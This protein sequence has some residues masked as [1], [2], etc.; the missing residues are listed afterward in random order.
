[1]TDARQ[2]RQIGPYQ[3][4][5]VHGAGSMG[6]V[7]RAYDPAIGRDVAVKLVRIDASSTRDHAAA[8]DRLRIEARA[9]GRCLHPGIVSVFDFVEQEGATPAIVMEF[10]EGR[11]LHSHLRDKTA[12]AAL[13]PV[14]L[15]RQILAPLGY[16]HSQASS[17][18]TSSRPTS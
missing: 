10:I 4:V 6:V 1:M 9:A 7:Y 5:D 16:A 14:A 17:I 2:P 15:V 13:D 3:I 8:V 12:R 18:A 11:S